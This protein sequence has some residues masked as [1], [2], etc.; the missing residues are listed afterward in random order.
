MKS[1]KNISPQ[2]IHSKYDTSGT[3]PNR[4]ANFYPPA[5]AATSWFDKSIIPGVEVNIGKVERIVMAATGAYLLYKAFSGSE[6]NTGK[7]I[8]GGTMFA[9]GVTGYCPVYDLSSKTSVLKSSNVNIRTEVTIN[10]PVTEVYAFWRNLE[11]LPRFMGH[12]ETVEEKDRITSDWTAKGPA[13]IGKVSWTAQILMD[14]PNNVLSWHSMPGSTIDNA[15]KVRFTDNG[16]NTTTLDVTISYHAPLGVAG[17]AA[18]KLLNPYFEKMV[19]EDIQNL[20]KY[21]ETGVNNIN[22]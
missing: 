8:M 11:N 12:L 20:K 22:E 5:P 19:K 3:D 15:G 7:A 21:L 13:G 16:D 9:R 18:A 10:R 14:E 1:S 2:S 6:K 17:E 4:Y